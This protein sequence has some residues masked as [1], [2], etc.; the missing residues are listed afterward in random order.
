MLMVV[1]K[2]QIS[3]LILRRRR[4][5]FVISVL[6][7]AEIFGIACGCPWSCSGQAFPIGVQ[8]VI[9]KFIGKADAS[10]QVD[11][12]MKY[13]GLKDVIEFKIAYSNFANGSRLDYDLIGGSSFAQQLAQNLASAKADKYFTLF[14]NDLKKCYVVWPEIRSY[15]QQAVPQEQL[16]LLDN[17]LRVTKSY[18]TNENL[19]GV[20][21]KKYQITLNLGKNKDPEA[22]VWLTVDE[23][24]LPVRL[25]METQDYLGQ[26]QKAT[27]LFRD[28]KQRESAV[29]KLEIPKGYAEI[30]DIKDI[31]PKRTEEHNR[32]SVSSKSPATSPQA[33]FFKEFLVRPP[34]FISDLVF[35]RISIH[36]KKTNV[37]VCKQQPNA[38]YFREVPSID[39]IDDPTQNPNY[40]MV[41]RIGS[42]SWILRNEMLFSSDDPLER[43]NDRAKM[44]EMSRVQD[45]SELILNEPLKMG[46]LFAVYRSFSWFT[47]D[48]LAEDKDG[49]RL[50]GHLYLNNAGWPSRIVY[51][52]EVTGIS[53]EVDYTYSDDAQTNSIPSEMNLKF[54]NEE[55]IGEFLRAEPYK[56]YQI[57]R[58]TTSTSSLPESSFSLEKYKNQVRP[59][60]SIHYSNNLAYVKTP[61]GLHAMKEQALGSLKFSNAKVPMVR[62]VI[63]V[64]M[65]GTTILTAVLIII[66]IKHNIK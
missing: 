16:I 19:N 42:K 11:Y 44:T 3:T 46:I 31:L 49:G 61:D 51:L 21:C 60:G 54:A 28:W 56:V 47:N 27:L 8:A 36:D 48:F 34:Q 50:L 39:A 22:L 5:R 6:F 52:R 66:R 13:S 20:R 26:N 41:S 58:Y 24:A 9:W 17:K 10:C 14:L 38:I 64:L 29:A 7:L 30:S 23:P 1:F 4:E 43:K 57:L 12:S 45:V 62:F 18:I 63:L 55:V 59:G 65:G 2:T 53:Y 33:E 32:L 40:M 37:Y 25:E 35:E 15:S